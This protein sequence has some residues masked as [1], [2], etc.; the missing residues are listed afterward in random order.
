MN[1][2]DL[3]MCGVGTVGWAAT[4]TAGQTL[5]WAAPEFDVPRPE[6]VLELVVTCSK[7]ETIGPETGSK[8]GQRRSIWP[9]I[10]GAFVGRDIKG[11]VVAGGGD[12]PLIRPDG[13][14][15][16]DAL[17][18]LRTDDGVTI[19]IHNKGLAMPGGQPGGRSRYRLSPE[20]TA[21][22]GK[23]DWLN[24]HLFVANLTTNLP[25]AKRLARSE[26]ENDRLIHVYR[27]V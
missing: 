26:N 25:D 7:P 14:T 27:L 22:N 10:G 24:K 5:D 19:I 15:V 21:P 11:V 13:V 16:I 17:Y 20:F 4:S 6:L 2:R 1:R 23:Y 8:D 18:R 12:F 9:I 3:L